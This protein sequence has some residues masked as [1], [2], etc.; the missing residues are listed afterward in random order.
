MTA[1]IHAINTAVPKYSL[2]QAEALEIAGSRNQPDATQEFWMNMI[3]SKSGVE[4]RSSV[5]LEKP[6]TD[7]DNSQP[8]DASPAVSQQCVLRQSFYKDA[9]EAYRAGPTTHERMLQYRQHAPQLAIEASSKAINS[10]ELKYDD[11]THLIT[12]SCTGFSAPGFDI[13]LIDQLGLSPQV[14]RTHVGFMGC[15]GALNA[16]RVARSISNAE[17][18]S[19]ILV[20]A[21]ELCSLHYQY[22]F[23]PDQIIANALFADGAAA[24]IIAPPLSRSSHSSLGVPS[25]YRPIE[26]M[27]NGS[28]LFPN[29]RDAMSWQIGDHG[30]LM[31]LSPQVPELIRSQLSHWMKSWLAKNFLSI[32]HIAHWAIHPGGPKIMDAVIESLGIDPLTADDSREVLRLYGNMSS[33][34]S[35]FVLERLRE[36]G[37]SGHC[38]MLGFGPGLVVEAV[39][40]K[41]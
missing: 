21:T 38:V 5:L 14:A 30:F 23:Q 27:A 32:E 15:H 29:T 10:A 40:M 31:T 18:Q 9:S 20:C 22:G 4:R 41:L 12:V 25:R 37:L 19:R 3:Y 6:D 2:T 35:L 28:F 17:P 24:M 7:S 26:L 1:V 16:M 34:T 11:L 13:D 39:L 33:P 8:T 36:K